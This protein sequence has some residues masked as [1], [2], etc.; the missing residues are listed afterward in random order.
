MWI[1]SVN[2]WPIQAMRVYL[3]LR[4]ATSNVPVI[5]QCLVQQVS[6][7]KSLA[8]QRVSRCWCNVFTPLLNS[9]I[10]FYS[11]VHMAWHLR[12]MCANYSTLPPSEGWGMLA[13]A[14]LLDEL[15][16]ALSSG[17]HT[18]NQQACHSSWLYR[19]R[20]LPWSW[21]IQIHTPCSCTQSSLDMPNQSSALVILCKS[22]QIDCC[23]NNYHFIDQAWSPQLIKHPYRHANHACFLMQAV[24]PWRLQCNIH[25]AKNQNCGIPWVIVRC[26][27]SIHTT[28]WGW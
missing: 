20:Q 17:D 3:E 14:N 12:L 4:P 8:L 10:V 28:L 26:H 5:Q 27:S 11:L 23:S 6:T 18:C 22:W 16:Q 15:A 19:S 25:I 24:G 21:K 7:L 1:S 9:D 13:W 2:C